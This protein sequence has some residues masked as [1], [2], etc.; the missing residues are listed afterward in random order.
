MQN[1]SAIWL[2]TVLLT[3]ACLYQISFSFVTSSVESEAAEFADSKVNAL[4]NSGET[5]TVIGGDT[6]VIT[7]EQDYEL[8]QQ[9]FEKVY[10]D[11][12]QEES[13][14]PLLG[15]TYNFC[16]KN[17]LN[18]GLDLKGGM[19]VTLE[20]SIPDLVDNLADN[21][22]SQGFREPFE[23]A[24]VK[25]AE[26]GEDF[27]DVFQSEFE[28]ETPNGKLALYFYMGSKE[29]FD[30]N[31]S[32]DEVVEILKEEADN[33]LEIT[34]DVLRSRIDKFGVMQP[35]IQRQASTGRIMIELPGVKDESRVRRI[36]QS[37]ANLEFYDVYRNFEVYEQLAQADYELSLELYPG[38]RD[39]ID[40]AYKERQ[41]SQASADTA[42]TQNETQ[43]SPD[44]LNLEEVA[45]LIETSA[46][47]RETNTE[48]DP[49]T[50]NTA[51]VT[52]PESSDSSSEIAAL[53]ELQSDEPDTTEEDRDN[54]EID[55]TF[56]VDREKYNPLLSFVQRRTFQDES[57][58]EQ[59][60]QT[61][62]FGIARLQDTARINKLLAHPT[63]QASLDPTLRIYWAAKPIVTE[64]GKTTDV[65]ELYGIKT[66]RDGEPLLTGEAIDDARQDFDPYTN[67]PQVV[68]IM[69]NT[70]AAEWKTITEERANQG[71]QVAIV[72]DDL[73]Y[74]APTIND[75]ISQGISTISGNFTIDE[76]N[77]LA[78][79]L[80]AGKLPATARIVEESI[81]G[82]TLGKDNINS[83]LTS[84]M[85]ALLVVLVYMIFYYGKAG[86]VADVALLANIFF[87]VGTLASLQAALT[88]PGIAGIVLTIGMSVDANVLIFER[89]R[90]ELRAGKGAK[91]AIQDGYKMAYGA[92]VDANITTLLTAI[93]LASFG[94]GPI[95]GF[96]TTLIIGIFTSL[97]SAIFITRLIFTRMLDK[98]RSISFANKA[99]ENVLRNANFKFIEKRKV[100]YLVSAVLVGVGLFSLVSRGLDLGVEFTGGRTYVVEF[101]GESAPDR[102]A[103]EARLGEAFADEEGRPQTPEVKTV[104]TD[105]KMRITTKYLVNNTETG[106]NQ[107]VED[108]LRGGLDEIGEYT[109][110]EQRSVDAA[111]SDDILYSSIIA[112]VFALII[113]FVYIMFRFRKWQF[114]LGALIAMFHDVLVVLGLFSLFWGVLPFS[115]EIDQAFI[116]AILTV[117][118]Y[119]INDTVVVFDRIRE[120]IN[121]YRRKDNMTLMNEA[122]NSTLSRTV[123]T[124]LTTFIVLLIIFVFGGETIR[125]FTFALLVGVVVGTYSSIFIAS[126][127]AFDLSK[128]LE[129]AR[130]KKVA[131]KPA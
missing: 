108:A 74:S 61:P 46:D 12:M 96:A 54:V 33:A 20:L 50:S 84:F 27:I 110:V 76:A 43:T 5:E 64:E 77:D 7:S 92:I 36:L 81:V 93:V 100:A 32:N 6:L 121:N 13:V 115:M 118:G 94:S 79:I 8:A 78:T 9:Y 40:L 128:N 109:I 122:L 4:K 106:V 66:S 75:V 31:M 23:R 39:S 62:V 105:Y 17:E 131:S 73:V 63:V 21:T 45:E 57:G 28:K 41:E 55:S 3:L 15:Y 53:Q 130:K 19:A 124:S 87:L 38:Y 52:E 82:P 117:V 103:V 51:E 90:E 123:N 91:L 111:I 112:I 58:V 88:L 59:W 26:S 67:E 30:Q 10:L 113:I 126:P 70:G 68:M 24:R 125:G 44:S 104:D 89:I 129:S 97:F 85:I 35:S 101:Q 69:N 56:E 25:S 86:A 47:T 127:V 72:L 120:Y 34:E 102:D 14:Y 99:T 80:K 114:G 116:A 95:Q 83:G 22:T 98:K 107:K 49:D 16:K 2:F 65:L 18:L 11:S 71:K 1:R 42:A 37:T 119:S 48:T 60:G 29:K